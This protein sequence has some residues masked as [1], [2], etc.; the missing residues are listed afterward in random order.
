LL[1]LRGVNSTPQ[2]IRIRNLRAHYT[3]HALPRA[4]STI[5]I[6]VIIDSVFCVCEFA[7]HGDC[8]SVDIEL[9]CESFVGNHC[10]ISRKLTIRFEV[11]WINCAKRM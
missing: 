3:R 9:Y 1:L 8:D 4:A 5:A 2:A 11:Y 10:G 6:S 7:V